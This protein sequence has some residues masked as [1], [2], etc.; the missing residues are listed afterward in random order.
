MLVLFLRTFKYIFSY[1]SPLKSGCMGGVHIALPIENSPFHSTVNSP[2]HS[3][4]NLPFH[5]MVNLPF[6]SMVDS[7]LVKCQRE[8]QSK[9]KCLGMFARCE[10]NNGE[11][12]LEE[13]PVI[14]NRMIFQQLHH[15]MADVV[16]PWSIQACHINA[17]FQMTI[18]M[19][20]GPHNMGWW[21]QST[22]TDSKFPPPVPQPMNN[23]RPWV[24]MDND[25]PQMPTTPEGDNL[26][27][28][29]PKHKWVHD[30][31][32]GT[33]HCSQCWS[34]PASDMSCCSEDELM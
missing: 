1:F 28:K 6:R 16:C 27:S 13:H 15:Q 10:C 19:M 33:W 2:F 8:F 30:A 5:S 32:L 17:D 25:E 31:G 3:T 4:V 7:V 24:P 14:S 11:F 20:P 34:C 29:G 9:G 26:R 18:P 23:D 12:F 21:H 22:S